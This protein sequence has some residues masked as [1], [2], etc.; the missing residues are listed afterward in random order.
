MLR[1]SL[2]SLFLLLL[3]NVVTA[4]FLMDMVDTT[5]ET[6]KGHVEYL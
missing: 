1:K 4:Q 6:G 3:A 2:L 5:T